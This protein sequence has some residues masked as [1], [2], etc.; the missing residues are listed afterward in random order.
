MPQLDIATFAPQ[1]VWLA[2]T[3]IALYLVMALVGL[4]RVGGIL[5]KRRGK[6]SSDLDKAQRMKAE[7][8]AVIAAY[9]KAL[10][11]ARSKAQA[12]LRETATRLNA[13]AAEQNRKL[14]EALH[15]ETAKAEKRIADAKTA[16][17]QGLKGM[18]AEVARA[19]AMRLA[20]GEVDARRIDAAVE[21]AIK[22]RG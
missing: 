15:A 11:E 2:I 6:I 21:A 7:A 1:L 17:L 3:F 22:E 5:E 9:E 8:E 16:A 10:A 12:A 18:A 13:E 4:P 19:A 20:G 14:A